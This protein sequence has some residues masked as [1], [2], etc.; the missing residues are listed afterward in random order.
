VKPPKFDYVAAGSVDEA[1]SALADGGDEA[2]V[3]AGGQSLMPLL[4]FRFAQPT[5]LVDLNRVPELAYVRETGDGLA[6]GAMTRTHQLEVSSEVAARW[7]LAAAAAPFIGHRQIRNRG[8]VG[9]SIAHADPAAELPAV[10]LASR[11]TLVARSAR[12]DR[13][14]P[15]A[16]FFVTYFTTALEPDEILAEIRVPA[17][18]KRTGVAFIEVARR[19]GDFALVGVAATVTLNGGGV[20]DASVVVLGVGDRPV[21]VPAAAEVLRG[22]PVSEESAREAGDAASAAIDPS[23][24]LHASAVYRKEVAAVLTRRAL[25]E[26][27]GKAVAR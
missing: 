19:H 20:A 12:G 18:P 6:V 25:L 10:A 2:K 15:A 11:A 3:L 14:I 23:G 8:T 7:P 17:P 13:E 1:L 9:G 26:A 4:A 21:A 5:L 22:S 27:A 24:D 16:E